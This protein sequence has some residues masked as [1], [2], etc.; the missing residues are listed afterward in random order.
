MTIDLTKD[1]DFK[2]NMFLNDDKKGDQRT[3]VGDGKITINIGDD[4]LEGETKN[5]LTVGSGEGSMEIVTNGKI[6]FNLKEKSK[7][8]A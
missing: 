5:P 6:E 8:T 4:L 2:A 3:K 7:L 1:A